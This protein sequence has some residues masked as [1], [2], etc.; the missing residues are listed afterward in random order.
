[1]HWN[2]KI[3]ILDKKDEMLTNKIDNLTSMLEDQSLMMKGYFG[4]ETGIDKNSNLNTSNDKELIDLT[5]KK[6]ISKIYFKPFN[7]QYNEKIWIYEY[8]GEG[9]Y[10]DSAKLKFNSIM[11]QFF[12][13]NINIR[14]LTYQNVRF[15]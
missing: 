9:T 6:V 8:F 10:I 13:K 11:N 14:D 2:E 4:K 5:K 12:I 15:K 7:G 3:R 1:M